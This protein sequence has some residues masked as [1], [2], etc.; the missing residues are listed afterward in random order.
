MAAAT[1]TTSLHDRHVALGAR[2]GAFAGW[3]MPLYYAG[4]RP[5]H[6]A[7]RG[8]AGLFDVS[9]MG[10]LEV[11]G[12][13]AR[14]A[15]AA[16]L[17]NDI[18]RVGPGQGQYTLLCDDDGGVIDD[19]IAYALPDRHLLVVNAANTAACHDRLAALLP[20]AVELADRSH[21]IAMLALQGPRWADA[22]RPLAG[23]PAAFG[24]GYFEIA[25]DVVA[26]VPCLISRTGYT[27]EP[28]VELMCPWDGAPELWD[29]LL[30]ADAAPEP[31]GL[32]SRD[33]LRL[34]MGYPLYGQELSRDRTPIEAGLRW[35]CDLEGGRFP[36]AARMRQQAERGTPERLVAFR[37]TEPG[38][39]RAGQD[40]LHDGAPAGRVTSGTL[41]PTLGAGIGMAYVAAELAA[42]GTEIAV[43][44]R[45][46][47]K[48]AVVARRPLVATSPKE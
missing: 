48:A 31:A 20:D 44:V 15:L 7:V 5:E 6:L 12:P 41:S 36:G 40:V 25:E 43:D 42:P 18:S 45:G 22:L 19:L 32:V 47:P 2:M 11:S 4:A 30:A 16:A 1:Q 21:E 8:R 38:I 23:T 26:G 35:A 28:G 27:G 9:H 34:E 10:Q 33:T 24:L 17:T 14:E 13:G 29:A 39:P 37:L 3:D 46:K